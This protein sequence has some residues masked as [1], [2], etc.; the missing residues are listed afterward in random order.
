MENLWHR[1]ADEAEE[2]FIFRVCQEKENIGSWQDVADILNCELNHEY[3][4]SKYRKQYQAFQR[5]F[6][7][8]QKRFTGSAMDSEL[9]EKTLAYEKA[10]QLYRD[11]RSAYAAY[12]R[13]DARFE[14]LA[15]KLVEAAQNLDKVRPF[16]RTKNPYEI[17]EDELIVVLS[18]WHFGLWTSNIW[19]RFDRTVFEQRYDKLLNNVIDIMEEVNPSR[20]HV[21]L[22][23]DMCHGAIHASGRVESEEKV[24]D[25]LMEVSEKLAIF[26]NEI[27]DFTREVYVYSTYGNHMRT[28]QNKKDSLHEDN[29]E[30]IIPWWLRT[31]FAEREDII[32]VENPDHHEFISFTSCGKQ[33]L[34]THG[35]LDSVKSGGE[36]LN[37]LWNKC[38]GKS[39]DYLLLGDKHHID[40]FSGSGVRTIGVGSLC[41][42]DDYANSKR[43]YD[44]PS[45]SVFHIRPGKG[46]W[47]TY[48]IEL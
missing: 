9:L 47:S 4:E 46:L 17:G 10:A 12:M 20:T 39:I 48:T 6:T 14:N 31:R 13:S 37:T 32:V 21:V 34:A 15:D 36:K 42:A 40:G 30:K 16:Q 3:T 1:R 26:I 8:N 33:I 24:C 22:L 25:E 5:M 29:F 28:V 2:E 11:Q 18:D 19:N 44:T 38:F 23:G 43:L 35:D 45:Q 7:A 41:G 27:S